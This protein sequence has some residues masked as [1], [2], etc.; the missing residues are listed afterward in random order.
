MAKPLT[1]QERRK[2]LLHTAGNSAVY[3]LFRG[4]NLRWRHTRT[5][6]GAVNQLIR[7]FR[8]ERRLQ[9]L[10]NI[11]H[12]TDPETLDISLISLVDNAF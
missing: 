6:R 4:C 9:A 12:C 5:K 10:D 3:E 2:I 11:L 8:Q 1:D 7:Y